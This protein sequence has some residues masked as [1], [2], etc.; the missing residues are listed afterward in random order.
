ML[1]DW[2]EPLFTVRVC[3]ALRIVWNRFHTLQ[4]NATTNKDCH[5]R[6]WPGTKSWTASGRGTAAWQRGETRLNERVFDTMNAINRRTKCTFNEQENSVAMAMAGPTLNFWLQ[7]LDSWIRHTEEGIMMW[8]QART[9]GTYGSCDSAELWCDTNQI[10]HVYLAVSQVST[11][12]FI[13]D[14]SGVMDKHTPEDPSSNGTGGD[15][16]SIGSAP[17]DPGPGLL[18]TSSKCSGGEEVRCSSG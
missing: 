18:D 2:E 9:T 7:V 17:L 8:S 1:R 15:V 6:F 3:T 13:A 12:C 11:R 14:V 10:V 4:A 16:A 5:K